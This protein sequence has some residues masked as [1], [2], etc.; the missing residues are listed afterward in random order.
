MKK[1]EFILNGKTEK[2]LYEYYVSNF[3]ER[4]IKPEMYVQFVK[5]TR[6]GTDYMTLEAKKI[7]ITIHKAA[8]VLIEQHKLIRKV[9][10]N[11]NDNLCI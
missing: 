5:Y 1:K 7:P 2:Q 9:K 10:R 11:G 3:T 6:K 4:N 8:S